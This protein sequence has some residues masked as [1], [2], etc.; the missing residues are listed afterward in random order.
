MQFLKL[1][2]H[3]GNGFVDYN[4]DEINLLHAEYP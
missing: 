2:R 3:G 1:K 4:R